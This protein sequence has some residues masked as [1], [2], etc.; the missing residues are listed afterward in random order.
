MRSGNAAVHVGCKAP[1]SASVSPF[2]PSHPRLS[3]PPML[4]ALALASTLAVLCD[5]TQLRGP[6]RHADSGAGDAAGWDPL[7]R[8]STPGHAATT[9][10]CL[11]T[12]AS[13]RGRSDASTTPSVDAQLTPYL[14]PLRCGPPLGRDEFDAAFGASGAGPAASPGAWLAT[15]H[16]DIVVR[17]QVRAP[18]SSDEAHPQILCFGTGPAKGAILVC[19][20][21]PPPHR[22]FTA[23]MTS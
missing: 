22:H 8:H 23:I 3:L 14:T 16:S 7:P 2:S 6:T 4:R 11:C 5:A 20:L 12:P 15:P 19:R 9:L 1:T 17:C 21:I 10:T 13:P 18:C